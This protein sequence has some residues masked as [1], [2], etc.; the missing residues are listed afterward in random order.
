M[1]RRLGVTLNK[2]ERNQTRSISVGGEQRTVTHKRPFGA[3]SWLVRKMFYR[4]VAL[5]YE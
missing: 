3:N 1:E 5:A 4:L 2:V